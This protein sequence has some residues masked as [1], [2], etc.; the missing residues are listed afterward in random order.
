MVRRLRVQ[1]QQDLTRLLFEIG[2]DA[3]ERRL[4]DE[5]NRGDDPQFT[6]PRVEKAPDFDAFWM[7]GESA[8]GR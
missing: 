5:G 2:L 4:L 3:L 8:E 1:N 7:F 6:L